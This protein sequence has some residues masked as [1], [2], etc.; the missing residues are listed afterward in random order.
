MNTVSIHIDE[1]LVDREIS[2]LKA[3]LSDVPHVVNVELGLVAPHDLMVEY[4]AHHNM[5][6]VILD[7]LVKQGL[8]PDIQ[9]C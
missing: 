6:L 8:H 7:K 9:N 3:S 1:T 2:K 4:E 5:P